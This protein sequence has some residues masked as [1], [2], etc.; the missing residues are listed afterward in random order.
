[1]VPATW[2]CGIIKQ[3]Y[4]HT[5]R[6][7]AKLLCNVLLPD[8]QGRHLGVQKHGVGNWRLVAD[9]VG[10]AS[11]P[12]KSCC[13]RWKSKH[14]P[15]L[16]TGPFSDLEDA[17]IIAALQV[18]LGTLPYSVLVTDKGAQMHFAWCY[19]RIKKTGSPRST[20]SS[21]I[22]IQLATSQPLVRP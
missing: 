9:E 3:Q 11:C 22:A 5:G 8:V 4:H 15:N 10:I 17:V 7:D 18:E 6:A 19:T 21:L 14:Q 16:I 20:F 13:Q 1:M 12:A 2:A